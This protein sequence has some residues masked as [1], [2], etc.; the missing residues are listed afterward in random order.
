LEPVRTDLPLAGVQFVYVGGEHPQAMHTT[1][2]HPWFKR[3]LVPA[4][5]RL[6]R[7]AGVATILTQGVYNDRPV[8]GGTRKS[9]HAFGSAIDIAGFV[10]P[11]KREFRVARDWRDQSARAF[12]QAVINE[13]K[14]AG[15]TYKMELL[16][17][18]NSETH[19]DHI[20]FGIDFGFQRDA[21]P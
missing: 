18:G 2:M 3:Q 19:Q 21:S 10:V 11:G 8:R 6:R 16:H 7:K 20:H 14:K 13:L 1:L 17:P 4:L 5:Q 9:L 12:W 15:E